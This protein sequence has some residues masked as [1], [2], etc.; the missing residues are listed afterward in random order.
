MLKNRVSLGNLRG[1]LVLNVIFSMLKYVE[2]LHKQTLRSPYIFN[3]GAFFRKISKKR[4][5]K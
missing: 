2:V 4:V 5:D 3:C 1:L